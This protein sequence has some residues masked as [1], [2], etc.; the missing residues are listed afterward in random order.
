MNGHIK[1]CST[2]ARIIFIFWIAC[3]VPL[4]S[5]SQQSFSGSLSGFEE[6]F[7]LTNCWDAHQ[8]A[9]GFIWIGSTKGL[10]RFDGLNLKYYRNDPNDPS[11]N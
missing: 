7:E 9:E 5:L 1:T 8:D 3:L 6:I 11:S 2:L 10:V 4:N